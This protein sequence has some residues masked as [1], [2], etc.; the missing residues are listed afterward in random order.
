MGEMR[1]DTARLRSETRTLVEKL[2]RP[3]RTSGFANTSDVTQIGA[4]L[5]RCRE[6]LA[7]LSEAGEIQ[8]PGEKPS[9]QSTHIPKLPF[10]DQLHAEYRAKAL[11][12]S[13]VLVPECP[14]LR[15]LVLGHEAVGK[16][17]LCSRITGMS[18]KMVSSERT[19]PHAVRED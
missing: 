13:E 2:P 18:E 8:D 19:S 7:F 5:A 10:A 15:I 14:K 3:S 9:T 1:Q 11:Q 12:E 6:Y 4:D 16:S 17:N